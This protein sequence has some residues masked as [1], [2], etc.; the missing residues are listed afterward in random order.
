MDTLT[1]KQVA[2]M[3]KTSSDTVERLIRIGELQAERLTPRGR[4]RI[5]KQSLKD[6]AERYNITLKLIPQK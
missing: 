3:L 6:Y 2:E 4:Y 1:T 5:I